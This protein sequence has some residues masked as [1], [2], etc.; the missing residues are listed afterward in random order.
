MSQTPMN[1]NQNWTSVVPKKIAVEPGSM[2]NNSTDVQ[3]RPIAEI[4]PK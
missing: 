2:P 4:R 1:K 3:S